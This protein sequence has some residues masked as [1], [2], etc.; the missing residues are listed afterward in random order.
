MMVFEQPTQ[1]VDISSGHIWDCFDTAQE[2]ECKGVG[3]RG[4][5]SH[6]V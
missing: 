4:D 5:N 2:K 3:N 6:Q 1:Y